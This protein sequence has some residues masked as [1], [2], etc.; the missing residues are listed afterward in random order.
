MSITLY[1]V[2]CVLIIVFAILV[3]AAIIY[4][5]RLNIC[6]S[7]PNPYCYVDWSCIN[8]NGSVTVVG[9]NLKN[10]IADCT[11]MTQADVDAVLSDPNVN[12]INIYAQDVPGRDYVVG[13]INWDKCKPTDSAYIPGNY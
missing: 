8:D 2:V 3:T 1:I 4:Q 10:W 5:L 9:A 12:H 11:P 13:D 6:A 7:N